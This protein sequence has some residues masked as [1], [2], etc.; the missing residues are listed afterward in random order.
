MI[1]TSCSVNLSLLGIRA[2]FLFWLPITGVIVKFGWNGWE[3]EPA[4]AER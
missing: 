3:A 4:V 2:C 1:A